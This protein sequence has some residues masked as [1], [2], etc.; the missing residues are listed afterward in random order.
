MYLLLLKFLGTLSGN[1]DLLVEKLAFSNRRNR[2]KAGR[3]M[4]ALGLAEK[5]FHIAPRLSPLIKGDDGLLRRRGL[6]ASSLKQ[7]KPEPKKGFLQ[8]LREKFKN[9]RIHHEEATWQG[10]EQLEKRVLLSASNGSEILQDDS[11]STVIDVPLQP[12]ESSEDVKSDSILETVEALSLNSLA[13]INWDVQDPQTMINGLPI[14]TAHVILDGDRDGVQ[15]IAEI[16]ANYSDLDAVHIFSHGQAGSISLGNTTL[17]T[18][19]YFLYDSELESWG[20]ALSEDGD[21]LFYGCDVAGNEAGVNFLGE[22]AALTGADVAASDD[23][24][25]KDGD[26]VL[27]VESGEIDTNEIVIEPF[28]F[29]LTPVAG[30]NFRPMGELIDSTATSTISINNIF[31]NDSDT[32]TSHAFWLTSGTTGT[33]TRISAYGTLEINRATGFVLYTLNN[34]NPTINGLDVGQRINDVFFYTITD[35]AVTDSARIRIRIN[36]RND[37]PVGVDDTAS[38]TELM[39]DSSTNSVS[40]GDILANDSDPEGHDFNL[41]TTGTTTMVG[42]YG[43]IEIKESDGTYKYF[44]D[45]NIAAVNELGTASAPLFDTFTYFITDT[46]IPGSPGGTGNII[47]TINGI[48]DSPT[49]VSN[50]ETITELVDDLSPGVISYTASAGL[51]SDD[52]DPEDNLSV[53]ASSTG[54]QTSDYGTVNINSDGSY[55]YTLNNTSTKVQKLTSGST[56]TDEFDYTITD[57]SNSDSAQVRIVIKGKEDSPIAVDDAASITELF[58]STAINSVNGSDILANDSDPEENSF[59]LTSGTAGTTTFA[60][61]YGTFYIYRSD[62]TFKYDLNNANATVNAL[63]TGDTLTDTFAYV[64]TDSNTNTGMGNI[65]VTINGVNDTPTFVDDSATITELVDSTATST[66]SVTATSGMLANDSDPED[67]LSVK[68]PGPSSGN[69]GNLTVNIDGS[70]SYILDNTNTTVNALGTATT[71]TETFTYTITDGAFSDT[72][73]LKIYINGAN[74]SPAPVND[75]SSITE[76]VDSTATNTVLQNSALA[77]TDPESDTPLTVIAGDI[78]DHTGS[79]GTLT[80]NANGSYS[81]NLDDA[82]ATVNAL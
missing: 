25:G 6:G 54:T 10:L 2:R 41:T 72:T 77:F 53:K 7:E 61:T 52:I 47:I 42:L 32:D 80:L 63:N 39:D 24:T 22:L 55:S 30:N 67:N 26:W 66:I 19:N 16:L 78:G 60:A 59:S 75:T 58:D 29:S 56:V 37:S 38:I 9:K 3:L 23:I 33:E 71:L 8:K 74:D 13:I 76:L 5:G 15:Q 14:G 48:N 17:S 12:Q 51:L 31:N 45:N 4:T 69:Y 62:G 44:L 65:I 68:N 50:T 49:A 18:E 79:F 28:N 46:S 81:Y 40:G 36:G 82:N 1:C 70:Y 43:T 35:G 27:E 21:I 11:T 73:V 64:I 20:N 57:S 34:T